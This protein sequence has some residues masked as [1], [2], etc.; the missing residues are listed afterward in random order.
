[1]KEQPEK[2][3]AFIAENLPIGRFGRVDEVA[4]TVAFLVSERASLVT[5]A[6]LNV[7]G[8]QSHSLI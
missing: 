5:G 6:C 2:M 4:D 7:D 1:M 8:G 3:K